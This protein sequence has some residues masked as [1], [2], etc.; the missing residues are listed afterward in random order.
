[1]SYIFK[2][3]EELAA[4]FLSRAEHEKRMSRR[5]GVHYTYIN[6]CMTRATTFEECAHVIQNTFVE[7]WP[8][9]NT[10]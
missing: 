2:S 3:R 7:Y 6:A 1:M 9:P 4:D 5:K 8:H 10:V